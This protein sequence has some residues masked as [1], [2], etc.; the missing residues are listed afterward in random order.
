MNHSMRCN[1]LNTY[2]WVSY[3]FG[4]IIGGKESD[5]MRP[6]RSDPANIGP[7]LRH[8]ELASVL[9]SIEK[10]ASI[11]SV[12]RNEGSGKAIVLSDFCLAVATDIMRH[13]ARELHIDKP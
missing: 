9:T 8:C 7:R 11:S 5:G 10:L 12:L 3:Y 4:M 2:A 1:A 6:P 13:V